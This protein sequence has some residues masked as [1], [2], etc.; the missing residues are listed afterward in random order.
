MS[1]PAT[2]A[3]MAV[4]VSST[5]GFGLSPALRGLLNS[6]ERYRSF[7]GSGRKGE[8]A[9]QYLEELRIVD[10]K[11]VQTGISPGTSDTPWNLN[12]VKTFWDLLGN[13]TEPDMLKYDNHDLEAFNQYLQRDKD[14]MSDPPVTE[15]DWTNAVACQRGYS[16]HLLPGQLFTYYDLNLARLVAK[17]YVPETD[18]LQSMAPAA[19]VTMLFFT[20]T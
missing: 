19:P 9:D 14:H 20:W 11:Y 13:Q 16:P 6:Y 5:E 17:H 7:V 8:E 2:T 15:E 10:R 18:S 12:N 1:T 4:D 3:P